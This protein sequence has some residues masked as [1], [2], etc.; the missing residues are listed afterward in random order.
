M[1]HWGSESG[2]SG[3]AAGK[4]SEP[5]GCPGQPV[6]HQQLPAEDVHSAI[7][8]FLFRVEKGDVRGRQ[9][10]APPGFFWF[11][12]TVL[13]DGQAQ[14]PALRPRQDLPAEVPHHGVP[15]RLLCCRQL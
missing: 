14:N 15:A 7:P 13:S 10:V 3:G 8:H 11:F 1:C 2:P 4:V 9:P 6:L 12:F 5:V